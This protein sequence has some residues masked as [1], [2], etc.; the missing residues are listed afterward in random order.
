LGPGNV[1]VTDNLVEGNTATGG[2]AGG[3]YADSHAVTA[4]SGTVTISRNTVI[5]NATSGGN[6]LGKG[7]GVYAETNCATS[8]NGGEVL[9]S[10]NTIGGNSARMGGGVYAETTSFTQNGGDVRLSGNI[11]TGNTTERDAG[12]VWVTAHSGSGTAGDIIFTNNIIAGNRTGEY[13]NAGGAWLRSWSSGSGTAGSMTFTNNTVTANRA[14]SG[15]GFY[16]LL[17][18]NVV[19]F[20]NNIIRDNKYPMGW[21]VDMSSTG[22]TS[23][24]NNNFGSV[25]GSWTNSGSNINS[26][27]GFKNAGSWNDNTTPSDLFDDI[28]LGGDFHL[29]SNSSCIDS[30]MNGAPEIPANDFED[31]LRISDGNRD[32]SAVA[33][34]GADE[35]VRQVSGIAAQTLLLL[36]P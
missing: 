4:N 35:F 26:N 15:D 14:N 10:E 13:F 28:W 30:G 11:I 24:Y 31:D 9:L 5:D 7:G 19:R 2:N 12:G 6:N 17:E 18:N 1:T 25:Y 20:Y 23:A 27:P 29:Q 3:I 21:D 34:I 32:G 16:V 33:D 36:S 8:G 22:T